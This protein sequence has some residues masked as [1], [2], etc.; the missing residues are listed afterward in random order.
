MYSVFKSVCSLCLFFCIVPSSRIK[1]TDFYKVWYKLHDS[2][3]YP[4]SVPL[5]S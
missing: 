4:N 2:G 3:L 1:F 5:I